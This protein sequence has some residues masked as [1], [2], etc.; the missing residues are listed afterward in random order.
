MTPIEIWDTSGAPD[1]ESCWP[2][3]MRDTAGVVLVYNPENE[4]HASCAGSVNLS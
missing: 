1:Y 4:G 3:V 2:A